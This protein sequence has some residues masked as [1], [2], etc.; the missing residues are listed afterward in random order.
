MSHCDLVKK[1]RAFAA[2]KHHGQEGKRPQELYIQHIHNVVELLRLH[3]GTPE[4]V[5]GAYLH[6][7]LEKTDTTIAELVRE[8]GE[9]VAEL[10]YWLTDPE[11]SEGP[12]KELLSTWLL[13]RAPIEAKLIKLAD[14]VDNGEAIR[15]H[16]PDK[17]S[18]FRRSKRAT[19]ERMAAVEGATFAQLALYKAA[20]DV[21]R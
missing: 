18:E 7:C 17:L 1:A 20:I 8:F 3:G 2:A 15:S 10:V 19:L 11:D 12:V 9:E 13:A 16:Q 5:T 4:M 14:I 21:T 6:D